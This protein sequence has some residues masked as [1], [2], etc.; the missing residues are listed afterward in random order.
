MTVVIKN[1]SK[2]G[3]SEFKSEAA[4]HGMTAGGFLNYLV[5]EH[6]KKERGGAWNMIFSRKRVL[7]KEEAREMKADISKFRAGFE[8]RTR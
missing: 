3:W 1:V 4:R 8:F 6:T 5:K 7:S 2:N